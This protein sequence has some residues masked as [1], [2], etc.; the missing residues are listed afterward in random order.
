MC[1]IGQLRLPKG[2]QGGCRAEAVGGEAAGQ[3][4]EVP[5]W[6]RAA[7]PGAGRLEAPELGTYSPGGPVP[8][9][10]LWPGGC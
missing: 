4:V 2:R 5:C 8:G 1:G 7:R 6:R 10:A 3:P 9:R